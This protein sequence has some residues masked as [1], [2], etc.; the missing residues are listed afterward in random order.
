MKHICPVCGYDQMPS[1]PADY[2]ICPSCGTEFGISDVEFTLD[3]LRS[4][5]IRGGYRWQSHAVAPPP[6]WNPLEQLE[7]VREKM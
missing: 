2:T 7:H 3:E 1:P 6:H 4:E 5:W